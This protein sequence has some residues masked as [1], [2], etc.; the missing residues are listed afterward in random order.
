VTLTPPGRCQSVLHGRRPVTV[1]LGPSAPVD[2]PANAG[3]TPVYGRT[4]TVDLTAG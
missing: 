1:D 4:V 2:D 3:A